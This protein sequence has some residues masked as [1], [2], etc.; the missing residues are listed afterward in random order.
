M[1]FCELSCGKYIQFHLLSSSKVAVDTHVSDTAISNRK[2]VRLP[3][4]NLEGRVTFV[5]K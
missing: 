2:R 4:I 3:R 5:S 1:A